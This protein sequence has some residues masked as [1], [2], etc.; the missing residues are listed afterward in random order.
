MSKSQLTDSWFSSWWPTWLSFWTM[1]IGIWLPPLLQS[2]GL[3]L[4]LAVAIWTDTYLARYF[5]QENDKAVPMDHG[6]YL[7][8]RQPR[9]SAAIVR[10]LRSR[11]PWPVFWDGRWPRPGQS[12]CCVR[13][14]W[15][16]LT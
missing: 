14:Q 8:V 5:S 13:S 16:R 2:V 9:Y 4:Y 6:P 1:D 3:G 7:Y 10:R 12:S 11:W 15:K